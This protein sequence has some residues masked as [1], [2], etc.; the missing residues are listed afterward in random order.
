MNTPVY[1][2]RSVPLS[3]RV[4]DLLV[5][6]T[7]PEKIGQLMQLDGSRDYRRAIEEFNVG[8]LFHLNGTDADATIF[9]TQLAMASS[10]D[11]SLLGEA[12]RVTAR[13]MRATGLKWT[14][15]PVLCIARDLRWGRIDETFGEDPYLIGEFAKAMIGGYQ[16][17]GLG[18]PE[19]V[20]ATAK[21][22][23][24]YSETAGGRDAAE[25]DLSRRALGMH[26]LHDR[27]PVH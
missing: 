23:A 4:D 25:A 20:L 18:D 5:R 3:V 21:H 16:G 12:A 10:W 24:G 1:H 22:Y 15:S 14:F 27:I 9:P 2:D 7:I 11:T 26:G 6:M 8:S 17:K 19:A 13:E